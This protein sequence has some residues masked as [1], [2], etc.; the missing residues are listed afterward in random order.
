LTEAAWLLR[1]NPSTV[2]SLL[3]SASS[4]L[5]KIFSLTEEDATAIAAV[6]KRYR[7]LKP[8][9]ADAALVHLAQRERIYTIFTLDRRD[10]QVYRPARSRAFR[11]LP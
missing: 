10:F 9:L 8:Q 5:F 2:E 11:I 3:G 4:G 6:L 7:N 1:S